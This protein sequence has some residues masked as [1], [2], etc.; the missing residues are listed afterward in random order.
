VLGF[1]SAREARGR[2]GRAL[3]RVVAALLVGGSL[4]GAAWLAWP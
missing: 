3:V 2:T 1:L 4:A